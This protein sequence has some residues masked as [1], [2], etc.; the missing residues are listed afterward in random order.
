MAGGEISCILKEDPPVAQKKR[1][2]EFPDIH[3]TEQRHGRATGK[4]SAK[5]QGCAVV[6][7]DRSAHAGRD[8]CTRFSLSAKALACANA[9]YLVWCESLARWRVAAL[10]PLHH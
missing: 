3:R 6:R 10:Q 1:A 4:N 8:H 2:G 9:R 5:R 7:L